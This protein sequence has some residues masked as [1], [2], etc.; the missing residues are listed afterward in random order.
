M[1]DGNTMLM[2]K[3]ERQRELRAAKDKWKKA[4][5]AATP[6]YEDGTYKS[7]EVLFEDEKRVAVM[8]REFT[9]LENKYKKDYRVKHSPIM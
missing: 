5:I 9:R 8:K 6:W 2:E 3:V 7:N 1:G 4:I